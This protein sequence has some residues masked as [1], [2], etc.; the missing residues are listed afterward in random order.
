MNTRGLFQQALLEYGGTLLLV[1]HDRFF[2]DNLAERV[3]EIRDGTLRSY[4]GNYS[5]FIEKRGETN[6]DI[7]AQI[8][9]DAPGAREKR[10]VEALERNRLYRKRKA[11]MDRIEPVELGISQAESRRDEIDSLLCARDVLADSSRVQSLMVERS[12]IEELLESSYALW[13]ELSSELEKIK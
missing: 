11:F 1:S 2:L 3:L 9:K 12:G 4:L 8:S 10:R 5:Y 7:C 6:P 13:E